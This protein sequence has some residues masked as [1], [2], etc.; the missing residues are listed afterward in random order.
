MTACVITPLSTR[1][2]RFLPAPRR[3]GS[4]ARPFFRA[5]AALAVADRRKR[6]G[7]ATGSLAALDA[8]RVVDADERAVALPA[9]KVVVHRA[10]RRQVFRQRRPLA[11]RAQYVHDPVD[12]LAHVRRSLVAAPL[13]REDQRRHQL[14]FGIGKVT[15]IARRATVVPSAIL[16]RPHRSLH[17]HRGAPRKHEQLRCPE[18]S[19]DGHSTYTCRA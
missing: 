1:T 7:R 11:A 10:A 19:P 6:T 2:G 5:R 13:G 14:P 9:P 12:D 8:E 16:V 3:R 15:R 18:V 4:I 17:S